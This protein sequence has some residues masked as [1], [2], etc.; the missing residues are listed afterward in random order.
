MLIV[1]E[2]M[3]N[4]YVTIDDSGTVYANETQYFSDVTSSDWFDP[5]TGSFTGARLIAVYFTNVANSMG[6]FIMSLTYGG[7]L[8]NS[9]NWKC[10]TTSFANW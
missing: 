2:R 9:S 1:K 6:G 10:T 8:T 7:C 5:A 3:Q 4:V